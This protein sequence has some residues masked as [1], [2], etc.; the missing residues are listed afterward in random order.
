MQRG[1]AL[2]SRKIWV[3]QLK[4]LAVCTEQ[5]AG[6]SAL[7][8]CEVVAASRER[9][10]DPA[11]GAPWIEIAAVPF[12]SPHPPRPLQKRRSCVII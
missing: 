1:A 3:K 12:F 7:P 10:G 4:G 6:P 2:K 9:R 8:W 11:Y 5:A